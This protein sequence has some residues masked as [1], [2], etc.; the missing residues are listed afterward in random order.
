MSDGNLYL[1][2]IASKPEGC[3]FPSLSGH[4][5]GQLLEFPYK[6]I[7]AVA[8]ET[9]RTYYEPTLE[10]LECH[11]RV[12]NALMKVCTVLPMSFS[13][14]CRSKEQID[15][16]L[17]QYY[18]QFT[19]NL[20]RVEGKVELGLK[21]FYR[22]DFEKEDKRDLSE[23]ETPRAYMTKRYDRYLDRKKQLDDV[24][25]RID[26]LH[27]H[28]SSL[29]CESCCTKPLKNNLIFNASYLVSKDARETFDRAVEE[30]VA[31]LTE[32]KLIYS[33]PWPTY[34]FV[35]IIGEGEQDEQR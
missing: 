29:A 27:G 34:H 28:L 10:N 18:G 30:A 15:R 26:S 7:F 35:K 13:T 32:Y 9:D 22:L 23:S 14:I 5:G 1:Y 24:L 11:E 2:C 21:I 6:D 33:G 20:A 25:S 16:M 19:E 12:I 8:G 3:V 17:A 4:G 31:N